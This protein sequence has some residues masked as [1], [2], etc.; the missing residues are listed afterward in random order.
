MVSV[1]VIASIVIA[2]A[3]A[4]GVSTY[5]YVHWQSTHVAKAFS[6]GLGVEFNTHA[7]PIWIALHEHLFRKYGL[8]VSKVLKFKTG[9]ELA[10]AFARGEVQAGW[11]CLGPALMIIARGV[12][13]KIIAKVHDYGYALVVNPRKISSIKDLNGIVVYAPGKGSPCYLLLLK[14]EERYGIKFKAIRFMKPPAALAAL[15][16]GEIE[17]AAI[18]EPYSSVAEYK[19]LKVLLRAQDI[20]PDMPGSF[21]VVTDSLLKKHPDVVRKLVEVTYEGIKILKSNPE[22]AAKIDSEVLGLPVKVTRHSISELQW[23]TTI[24]IKEIQKYIDFM[25]SHG[26]LKKRLNA[27]KIV[28]VVKP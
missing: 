22:L 3:I 16:S 12:P 9:L 18:P 11:A 23:N 7:T 19:G 17:A 27:S 20:W 8:N 1:R 21:L 4:C 26:I 13:L 14:V 5:A 2:V 15:L 28:V 24:S 25:Y 10:A 6:I